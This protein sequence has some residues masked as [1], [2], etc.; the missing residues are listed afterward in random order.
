MKVLTDEEVV[1]IIK[2]ATTRELENNHAEFLKDLGD[3]IAKHFGGVCDFVSEPFN[4]TSPEPSENRWLIG[5]KWNR[6]VPDDGGVYKNVDEEMSIEEWK[7][8]PWR[9]PK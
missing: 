5:F 3:V 9:Q 1:R 7:A 6:F 2:D 8:D 4:R